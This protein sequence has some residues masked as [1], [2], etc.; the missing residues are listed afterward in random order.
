MQKR[1]RHP[2][3]HARTAPSGRHNLQSSPWANMMRV[4]D[5]RVRRH[6][7]VRWRLHPLD[8]RLFPPVVCTRGDRMNLWR[9]PGTVLAVVLLGVGGIAPVRDASAAEASAAAQTPTQ[10]VQGM[11]DQLS[12]AVDGHQTEL[13]QHP[14]QMTNIIDRVVLPNFDLPFAALL[15]LGQY[16]TKTTP[17]QRV[18][19]D[20]AFYSAL[21]RGFA[22]GLIDF[23]QVHVTVLP[24]QLSPSQ[25]RVLV[26][27]QV[28]QRS[29][30]TVA[31]DYAF[32][33]SSSG[34]WKIYDVIIEGI[35]YITLYRSQVDS[36]IQKNGI[37]AVTERLSTKGVVDL[38]N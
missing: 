22:K 3:P 17:A 31:V 2:T 33:K 14:E 1:S 7:V 38:N 24:S 29:G 37:G 5:F 20:H 12:H 6:G 19:F 11:V 8:E 13:K 28:L 32:H 10:V 9:V 36:D 23:T 26:R 16:A 4:K 25:Q 27:T 34:G 15:V 21:A 35:S 30:D 18:A